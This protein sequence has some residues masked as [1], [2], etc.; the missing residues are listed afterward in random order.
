MK[1]SVGGGPVRVLKR[2]TSD[3]TKINDNSVQFE[4]FDDVFKSP[5]KNESNRRSTIG[6]AARFKQNTR[7]S[8]NSSSEYSRQSIISTSTNTTRSIRQSLRLSNESGISPHSPQIDKVANIAEE[9]S[10]NRRWIVDDF[11]LGKAIGKGKFGNVYFAR[12]KLTNVQVALKVLFK[13]PMIAANSV[14]LLQREVEIQC[15]M[16]HPNI[17]YLYGYFDDSKHIYLILE[18]LTHGELFKVLS[19]SQRVVSEATCWEY[20]KDV[21]SALSYM[22][23]RHIIHR[24]LKPENLLLNEEGKLKLG[25]FGW[26]VHAPPPSDHIRYT[27]CGTPEYV[28]PEIILETGHT[29]L[30]DL[31]SFGILIFELLFARYINVF[32]TIFNCLI[33]LYIICLS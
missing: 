11:S 4:T 9:V 6:S 15:R 30:V 1:T 5:L 14:Y 16:K 28:A 33:L 19:K 23:Q 12:Q 22:H 18:Y 17:V 3:E 25:D 32:Y 2:K 31:W 24:D 21:S 20:I 26:A 27:L 13:V 10:K 8:T 7:Q 29:Y